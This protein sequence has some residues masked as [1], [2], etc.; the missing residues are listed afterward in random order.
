MNRVVI[1]VISKLSADRTEPWY[2]YVGKV[3]KL[4]NSTINSSIKYTPFEIMFG[5]KMKTPIDVNLN[6]MIE[7]ETVD[8]VMAERGNIR[9]KANEEI[10][11]AQKEYKKNQMVRFGFSI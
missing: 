7:A 2:K 3:Q 9:E 8:I 4:V 11:A 10:V 5:V 6:E 1:N